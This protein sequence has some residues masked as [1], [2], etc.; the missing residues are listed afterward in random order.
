MTDG[1]EE[2]RLTLAE[3]EE[4]LKDPEMV[5]LNMLRGGIA[6]PSIRQMLHLHGA[7]ALAR[8]DSVEEI[9]ALRAEVAALRAAVGSAV[10]ALC[11]EK[12]R[13]SGGEYH[14]PFDVVDA[15]VT[16]GMDALAAGHGESALACVRELIGIAENTSGMTA[17]IEADIATARRLFGTGDSK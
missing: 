12:R 10:D 17:E 7:D 6:K 9:A 2:R 14:Y 1:R 4:T 15:G 11:S 3:L 16:V 5:Y 8:W 13:R